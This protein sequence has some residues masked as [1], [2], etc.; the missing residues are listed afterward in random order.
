MYGLSNKGALGSEMEMNP[1]FKGDKEI[2]GVVI[3]G[4]V[5]PG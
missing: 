3:W 5:P 4:K 2:K 1:M